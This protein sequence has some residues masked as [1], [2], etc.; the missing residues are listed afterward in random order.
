MLLLITIISIF[1][2]T[3]PLLIVL[4]GAFLNGL[5]ISF[6]VRAE[7]LKLRKREFVEAA[8]RIGGGSLRV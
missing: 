3:M 2:P 7:F 8:R 5:S 6:Y 1:S 4:Y